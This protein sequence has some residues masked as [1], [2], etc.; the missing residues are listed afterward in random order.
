MITRNAKMQSVMLKH[1]AIFFLLLMFCLR[2]IAQTTYVPLWA[3]ESW[4]LDRLEIKARTDNNLN[5]STVKPYMRKLYVEV[6]DSFRQLLT[7]GKNPARLTAVDQ[8]NL[9]RFQAN[10]SEFSR[11][12]TISMPGWK[13]KKDFL[14]FLWPTKGNMVEVNTKD[15]YLSLNPAINQ[16]QSIETDFDRR[17]F[18]NSKGLTLRGMIAGKI[19]FHLYATDNQE[20]GPIQYRQFVDSN[21]A[22]P[23]AGFN[24]N[25]KEGTGRDYFDARGSVTWNV[26]KFVNMQ[27]GFDQHFIGNGYRSLFMGNFAPPNLFLKFNT[28]FGKFNYTNIFSE[29]YS[30]YQISGGDFLNPKQYSSTHH[31][32]FNATPWLTLGAFE[33]VVWGD[34]D[35]IKL[36]YLQPVIFLNTLI[37]DKSGNDNA[38]I[39]FDV[40][41]NLLQHVQVYGQWIMQAANE[42]EE[43]SNGEGWANRFGFQAGAKYVDAFG[44]KNLDLQAEINQVRPFTYS[45]PENAGSWTNYRQAMAHPFGGNFRELI[46]ILRYQPW[47][48]VYI[49]GR[50]NYWQQGRDSSR[51]DF[52]SNPRF[53]NSPVGQGG[54]RRRN[55][56]YPMF[57]GTS[58]QGFNTA[59]TISYELKENL[60]LEFNNIYRYYKSSRS[61][62][63]DNTNVI[64]GGIR[65]NMFRRDYDY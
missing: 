12:D 41:A 5:L 44:L 35:Q 1:V 43:P 57:A 30:A 28:R 62:L 21:R 36:S 54:R 61:P 7:D 64:T 18:V 14:G 38:M 19:G 6:A 52:G 2:G 53:D 48:K 23:G 15:F 3:K 50:I 27:F 26:S 20:Q 4:L 10:N 13:S 49:F 51:F 39:G 59:I 9:D 33:S 63:G 32:S 16:Q 60:F 37:R 11:F 56:F 45:S 29:L 22:V 65:W 17:V 31:L 55:D 34:I 42:G 47:K 8:Y 24:K 25:F 58:V 46:G 40:K